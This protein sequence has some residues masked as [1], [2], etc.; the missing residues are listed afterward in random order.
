MS[1]FLGIARDARF[2]PG[3][4]EADRRILEMTATCLRDAGHA[5]DMFT[6]TEAE[7]PQPQPGT[8][9]FTMSQGRS[10][11]QHLREWEIDGIRVV[12]CAEAILNCQRHRTVLLLSGSDV[13]FPRTAIVDTRSPAAESAPLPEW[14]DEAGAWIKRGD[15]HAIDAD[16]V[17]YV[18]DVAAAQA[19]L[20]RFQERDIQRAVVQ[21]HRPGTVVKFYG[22]RGGFFHC[23]Q[24]AAVAQFDADV[25]RQVD[26]VGRRAADTLGVEIYG[27]D[28]V[29]GAD[30]EVNLIDLNDWPSYSACLFGASKSIATHLEKVAAP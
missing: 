7:W 3:K 22:V 25:L 13:G 23:V 5:I 30:G 24:P 18:V 14:I 19:A 9:V 20:A 2:S 29:I 15:V 16:D 17:V 4:V 10:A 26:A 28:C 27:G 21:Q 1:R 11:L 12:N 8:V 6:E